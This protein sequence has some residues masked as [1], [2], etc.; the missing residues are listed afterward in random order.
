[1]QAVSA[2]VPSVHP[3][4]ATLTIGPADFLFLGVFL[5]CAARFEMGLKKNAV[6]LAGVLG[7]S[8]ALVQVL[9]AIPALAPMSAAFVAVNWRKFRLTKQELISTAVVLAVMGGLFLAYFLLAYPAGG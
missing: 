8:L 6:V 1:V 7:L 4:I 2:K 3:A 9:P 5:A